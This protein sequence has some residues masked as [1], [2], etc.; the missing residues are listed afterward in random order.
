[1]KFRKLASRFTVKS[2]NRLYSYLPSRDFF[3]FVSD[4]VNGVLLSDPRPQMELEETETVDESECQG[5]DSFEWEN[6]IILD[7]C[8]HDYYE[9]VTGKEVDSRLTIGGCSPHFIEK[10]F[11][12]GDWSDVIYISANPFTSENNLE[13]LT[14]RDDIFHTVWEVYRTDWDDELGVVHPDSV[15]EKVKTAQQLY[16]DKRKII[17]FMQPHHPFLTE[18]GDKKR[19]G[20]NSNYVTANNGL[21]DREQLIEGY[22]ENIL[23]ALSRVEQLENVLKG[24]TVVTADHGELLGEDGIYGHYEKFH[25]ALPLRKV[26]QDVLID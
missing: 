11:S 2:F 7:A 3:Y 1:M 10:N 19:K 25:K 20:P 16:P 24:R 12:E 15:V 17:H 14:G 13:E 18:D 5:I 8:R 26:P 23:V 22:K 9:E 6:L 4:K 21:A